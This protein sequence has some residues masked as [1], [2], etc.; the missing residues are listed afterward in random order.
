[1]GPRWEKWLQNCCDF[2]LK[3]SKAE[4]R[5]RISF[6]GSTRLR[7]ANQG[8]SIRGFSQLL[9]RA[10]MKLE[11]HNRRG[12]RCIKDMIYAESYLVELSLRFD[13]YYCNLFIFKTGS[14]VLAGAFMNCSYRF[15]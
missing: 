6:S 5:I 7:G 15:T 3:R 8:V 2:A 1:M 11:H 12:K 13:Y 10:S 9:Q 14:L 4:Q